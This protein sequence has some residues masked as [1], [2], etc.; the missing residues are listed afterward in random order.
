M[1]DYWGAYECFKCLRTRGGTGV[2]FDVR[3]P[4]EAINAVNCPL[5]G[6]LCVLSAQWEATEGG[7]GSRSET[8]E[9]TEVVK[10]GGDE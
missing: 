4:G 8:R 6:E 5:C 2:V 9:P 1:P 7:Y 10:I 3:T